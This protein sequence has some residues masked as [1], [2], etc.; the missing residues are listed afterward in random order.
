MGKLYQKA[1]AEDF[2]GGGTTP[3]K[4]DRSGAKGQ[5][6][7]TSRS[8]RSSVRS[9]S[10]S[11]S[12]GK[13]ATMPSG[14]SQAES[15]IGDKPTRAE[16]KPEA[17]RKPRL[18]QGDA[19]GVPAATGKAR[20]KADKQNEGPKPKATRGPVAKGAAPTVTAAP[21]ARTAS[22][23]EVNPGWSGRTCLCMAKKHDLVTNCTACGKIAC[24]V[25]GGYGCSFCGS[26]LPVTGRE[27]HKA[28]IPG[29]PPSSTG[30]DL[31]AESPALKEALARKERLLLFDRTSA[32]RTRVLDDQGDYF[33]SHNWLSQKE[34]EKAAEQERLHREEAAQRRGARRQVK[35]SIDI[36]GRKVVEAR[37]GSSDPEG[38]PDGLEA[39]DLVS[40]DG[41]L[42]DA[43]SGPDGAAGGGRRQGAAAAEA[44]S[45]SATHGDRISLENKG[46]RGRAREV[47]AVMRA[48]LE[49]QERLRSGKRGSR[50][51]GRVP[52][53]S[54]L[55]LWRV[56]HDAPL[57]EG[58][59]WGP[60]LTSAGAGGDASYGAVDGIACG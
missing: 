31:D 33:T 38:D 59:P 58:L 37:D 19:R 18:A 57:D 14:R 24:V 20:G 40:G 29:S 39:S 1:A 42:G 10:L 9:P 45:S 43:S 23:D 11:A 21:A 7:S 4:T 46:L 49:K 44:N 25:E 60:A 52:E 55:S 53:R 47:Y 48:N 26:S 6:K 30:E 51:R 15:K 8:Q 27:P 16:P 32:S 34:R 5:P 50:A 54:R 35:V 41:A 17:P 28:T 56:Q 22:K 36:M 13:T 2:W 3:A 12:G